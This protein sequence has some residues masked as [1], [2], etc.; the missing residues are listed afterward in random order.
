MRYTD[1]FTESHLLLSEPVTFNVYDEDNI[2]PVAQF[3]M[4]LPNIHDLYFDEDIRL[5]V[6]LLNMDLAEV[7]NKFTNLPNI[8]SYFAF[9]D[10]IAVQSNIHLLYYLRIL[11]NALNKLGLDYTLAEGSYKQMICAGFPVTEVFFERIRQIILIS[12][13]IKKPTDFYTDPR[14][15]AMQDKINKIKG[16]KTKQSD[17]MHKSDFSDCLIILIYEFGLTVP[18]IETMTQYAVNFILGYTSKSVRYKAS[19]IA[20]GNGNTKKVKFITDKGK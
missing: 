15:K 10:S 20:V 5:L 7:Q 13:G 9:Y 1:N 17:A 18:Y 8:T 4:R 2:I 3:T 16:Q 19:L 12:C 14:L 6:G 11:V